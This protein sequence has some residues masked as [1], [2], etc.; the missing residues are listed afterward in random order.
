MASKLLIYSDYST[1]NVVQFTDA[2]Y[3]Q[4]MMQ[5]HVTITY[6]MKDCQE[7]LQYLQCFLLLDDITSIKYYSIKQLS[8]ECISNSTN[9]QSELFVKHEHIWTIPIHHY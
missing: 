5:M 1:C 8:H 9:Q 7:V 2:H 4:I 6:G 3:F